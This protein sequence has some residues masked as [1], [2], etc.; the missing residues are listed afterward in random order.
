MSTSE[1]T[2][3]IAIRIGTKEVVLEYLSTG[4]MIADAMT[5]SLHGELF[6]RIRG[7]LLNYGE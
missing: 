7:L 2:R 3:H 1:R 4:E 6:R 5:K